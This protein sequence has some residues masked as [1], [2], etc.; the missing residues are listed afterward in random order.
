MR[1]KDVGHND[2]DDDDDAH[3]LSLRML[4]IYNLVHISATTSSIARLR[5]ANLRRQKSFDT[6]DTDLVFKPFRFNDDTEISLKQLHFVVPHF[7]V[8]RDVGYFDDRRALER[9]GTKTASSTE[10]SERAVRT[11]RTAARYLEIY[12]QDMTLEEVLQAALKD[13]LT[14]VLLTFEGPC[15][16]QPGIFDHVSTPK[17]FHRQEMSISRRLLRLMPDQAS[18]R[19]DVFDGSMSRLRDTRQPRLLTYVLDVLKG[20]SS[21]C[22]AFLDRL[23]ALHSDGSEPSR[24]YGRVI[25]LITAYA[26]TEVE[27]CDAHGTAAEA[28]GIAYRSWIPSTRKHSR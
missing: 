1:R 8:V 19:L 22:G 9:L 11:C 4:P 13:D 27:R 28:F 6:T 20:P 5:V 24:S 10:L 23:I 16:F 21:V 18:D 12:G 17:D 7:A 3:V 26:L 25:R 2:D 15:R 14:N